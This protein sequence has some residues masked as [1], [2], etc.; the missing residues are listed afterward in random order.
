MRACARASFH[1]IYSIERFKCFLCRRR[2]VGD[3]VFVFRQKKKNNIHI[4]E[5]VNGN[6]LFGENR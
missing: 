4:E 3:F 1:S 2:A 5:E 6:W